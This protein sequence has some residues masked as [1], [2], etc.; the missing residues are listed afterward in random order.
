MNPAEFLALTRR[1]TS[2]DTGSR[3]YRAH[4]D[5]TN[6]TFLTLHTSNGRFQCVAYAQLSFVD[7]DER[8]GTTMR[9]GSTKM[10]VTISG[11]QL[12]PVFESIRSRKAAHLY[13]F[14]GAQ[15]DPPAPGQ[16]VIT[17]LEFKVGQTA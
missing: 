12:H 11:R 16:P 8:G 4:V 2:A 3:I 6:E 1:G 15:C 10:V 9:L 7:G 14:D 17:K 13:E 5:G